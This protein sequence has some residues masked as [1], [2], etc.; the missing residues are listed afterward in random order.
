M[1]DCT[2]FLGALLEAEV[3][4]LRGYADTALSHHVAQCAS[5]AAAAERILDANRALDRAL[6]PT[7]ALDV[8]AVLARA[9]PAAA[10]GGN[11]RSSRR[12]EAG[13]ASR[14]VGRRWRA[15]AGLAAA[16]SVAALI[17]I[18]EREPGLPGTPDPPLKRAQA[19]VE[20]PADR[21]V[22]VIQTDNPDITV[23]WFF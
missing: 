9:R 4:E 10:R 23:L 7:P 6:A 8:E 11:D 20:A 12:P 22:A 14:P 1:S 17:L 16:A 21:K 13:H 19:L 5:C 18:S 3:D 2:N 15:W